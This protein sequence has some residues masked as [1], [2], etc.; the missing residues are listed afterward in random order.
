MP[1]VYKSLFAKYEHA[2]NQRISHNFDSPRSDV[3]RWQ[4]RL[5]IKFLTY[6][7]PV[8]L[9]ALIP[10]VYISFKYSYTVTG[11]VD[12]SCFLGVA[13]AALA[14]KLKIKRRKILIISMF[15]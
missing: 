4:D 9:V 7:L 14:K 12:I 1:G 13:I 5:F 3:D 2:V 15:Y 11:I 10:C 6:C 8:S